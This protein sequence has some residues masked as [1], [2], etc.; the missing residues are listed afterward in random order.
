MPDQRQSM[1]FSATMPGEILDLSRSLLGNPEKVTVRPQQATA[2]KVDQSV[3]F[4]SKK[5][6]QSL[7]EHIL[8]EEEFESALIFSRTK[9]GANKIV[10]KL[11]KQGVSALAIHGN[12]SQ[13]ARQKA[14]QQFKDGTTK[15]LVATDIAARGIDVSALSLV[16]NYDLPQVPETYV[17][18]IGRTGRA[19]MSGVALSFCDD[20]E[21]DALRDIQ[22]LLKQSIP[23]IDGHPFV[24]NDQQVFQQSTQTNR[25]AGTGN[26]QDRSGARKSRNKR[27]NNRNK[28]RHQNRSRQQA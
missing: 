21:F 2:D 3:Y 18:R 4:V 16:I 5:E 13:G 8:E 23:V 22:K 1:F 11:E 19:K 10:R 28:P 20:Q 26:S 14:L 12:K 24:G 25:Q 17:H 9:H 7:L 15:V 6:K 27:R